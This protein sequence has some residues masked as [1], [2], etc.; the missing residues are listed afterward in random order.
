MD[1]TTTSGNSTDGNECR[2]V[3]NIVQNPSMED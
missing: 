2:C 1:T 3:G